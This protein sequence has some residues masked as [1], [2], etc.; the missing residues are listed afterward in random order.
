[1]NG[2]PLIRVMAIIDALMGLVQ[3]L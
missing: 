3:L 1:L 2:H